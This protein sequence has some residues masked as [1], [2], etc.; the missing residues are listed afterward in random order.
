MS[1]ILVVYRDQAYLREC[2]SSILDQSFPDLK[3]LAID[4]ASPDHGPAILDELEQKDSRLQVRHLEQ[5]VSRG[6]A[7]NLALDS[8]SGD[9][10]WFVETT[11]LMPPGSL[12]AVAARLEETAPDALLVD[13]TRADSMGMPKP[14]AHQALIEAT[15]DTR[16]FA[17]DDRPELA[18]TAPGVWDKI[19]RRE[20]LVT[21][22]LRF[23]TGGFDELTV[24]YPALLA[25]ERISVLDRV[26]YLRREPANAANEPRIH[27][28]PFDVFGRYDA[29][30]RF[31]ASDRATP[32]SRRRLLPGAMLRHYLSIQDGLP[33]ARREE[34]FAQMSDS[35]R[36][37]AHGDEPKPAGRALQVKFRLVEGGRY[38]A[39]QGLGWA[40]DQRRA[41]SRRLE[42][43]RSR[44]G[45]VMRSG[46]YRALKGYYRSQ[47]RQ[48]IEPDLA[49]FAAYWFSGYACNPRAIYEKLR[50]L[51]PWIRGAWVV[52]EEYASGMPEDVPYVVAGSREYYSLIARAKYFVNNVGFPDDLVKRDGT[53]HVQT[54]H[55]VPLKKMGLDQ[56]DSP[57][58]R[59]PAN[60]ERLLRR[61]ARWDY[62]ISSNPFST[63]I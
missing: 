51:A 21:L 18:T 11:D 35:Y 24:T 5:S 38:G 45:N 33:N 13:H 52:K 56:R 55:G 63:V 23:S 53:V 57:V 37:H 59:S 46:R 34:F 58:A 42:K 8:A 28:T 3:L 48:P 9:Y 16:T 26:C 15:A 20:F 12:A 19:F 54:H 44:A 47:L 31:A 1:V 40:V 60:F 62:F 43:A 36:R 25:V 30:F 17:R 22:G 61:N 29:V 32:S 49:V 14:G 4:N 6:E 10:V 2:V 7:R 27:G 50:E 39:F 41:A